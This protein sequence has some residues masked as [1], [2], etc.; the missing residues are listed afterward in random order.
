VSLLLGWSALGLLRA[1]PAQPWTRDDVGRV[2]GMGLRRLLVATCALSAG[3]GSPDATL[4]GALILG[5][6]PLSY[7]LRRLFPPT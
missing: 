4:V 5:G 3:L 7:A 6:Y 2:V 1:R